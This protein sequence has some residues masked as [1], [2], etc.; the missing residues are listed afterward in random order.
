MVDAL[1]L[2]LEG[3][4]A[5][6]ATFAGVGAAFLLDE[7]VRR[8]A[9][10]KEA[11]ARREADAAA[12]AARRAALDRV[13]AD[14][15]VSV[16]RN[17]KRLEE[18]V[19]APATDGGWL[20]VAQLELGV[21]EV[22]RDRLMDLEDDEGVR[23]NLARYFE[24]LEQLRLLVALGRMERERLLQEVQANR[25]VGLLTGLVPSASPVLTDISFRL[26]RLKNDLMKLG[27]ELARP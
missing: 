16:Q 19:Q 14:L 8:K 9:D 23:T 18:V 27:I 26:S 22:H 1:G 12:A 25:A 21:W 13:L 10:A 4:V 11:E 20:P 15:R 7:R 5:F 3:S 6:A 24:G 2:A 17:N